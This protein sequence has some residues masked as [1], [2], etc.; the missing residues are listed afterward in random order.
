[1]NIDKFYNERKSVADFMVRL[2]DRHLTTASGGNISLKLNDEYF[3]ITPTALDK[4]KLTAEQIA[5]VKFDGT[6]MTPDLKLSIETEM[7]RLTLLA[8]PEMNAVVHAHPIYATS[9][10]TS[11]ETKLTARYTA[12]AYW[13]VRDIVNVPYQLMGTKD[14]AKAVST[15]MKKNSVLLMENHGAIAAAETLLL[16]FDKLELLERAAQM[17]IICQSIPGS[18]TISDERCEILSNWP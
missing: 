18:H 3:C 10:S 9:F 12:E 7:H 14:L 15:Q 13:V 5:V 11:L 17:Q 1:M 4:G 6:N 2:Y 8:C 16:A